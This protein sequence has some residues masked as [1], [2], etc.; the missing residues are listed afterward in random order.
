MPAAITF[1]DL[2]TGSVR[3]SVTGGG[4]AES[5]SVYTAPASGVFNLAASWTLGAT[6]V[7]NTTADIALS[8]GHYFGYMDTASVVT[9]PQYFGVTNG[10]T[11]VHYR[12]LT[13]IQSRIQSLTLTGLS[14]SSVI[15]RKLSVDRDNTG[16]GGSISYPMIVISQVGI[17]TVS[18]RRGSNVRDDVEYPVPINILAADNQDLVTNQARYLLWRQTIRRAFSDQVLAGVSEVYRT[19]AEPGPIISP[20]RFWQNMYHSSLII[21]CVSREARGY[22]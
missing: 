19:V 5:H 1:T 9:A 16:D 8:S 20:S 11:A 3:A 14:S 18:P 13:A 2:T 15:I 6:I 4:G 21:R 22:A 17:E 10:E 7:G 12:C